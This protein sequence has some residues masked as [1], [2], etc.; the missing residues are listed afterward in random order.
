MRA[1]DK[2]V[3]SVLQSFEEWVQENRPDG[4]NFQ[5]T[6]KGID[7][8]IAEQTVVVGAVESVSNEIDLTLEQWKKIKGIGPTLAKRLVESGPYE[9]LDKIKE[10]KGISE[11]T[12][13][14]ISEAVKTTPSSACVS[15]SDEASEAESSN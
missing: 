8:E 5:V 13:E 7:E 12:L 3:G 11:R 15:S 9:S 10:I 14:Q 1:I 6:I 2:A 4:W